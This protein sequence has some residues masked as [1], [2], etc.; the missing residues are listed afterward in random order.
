MSPLAPTLPANSRRSSRLYAVSRPA[1]IHRRVLWC[2]HRGLV[3]IQGAAGDG[4]RSGS[5]GRT[6]CRRDCF[7]RTLVAVVRCASGIC[8]NDGFYCRRGTFGRVPW[9]R[10]GAI[11]RDQRCQLVQLDQL[12]VNLDLLELV[13]KPRGEFVG[14]GG[15]TRLQHRRT[16]RSGRTTS[17]CHASTRDRAASGQEV[18][19]VCRRLAPMNAAN[20]TRLTSSTCRFCK[21]RHAA[22]TPSMS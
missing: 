3:G 8:P 17:R 19:S 20:N 4:E 10:V 11:E 14:C 18:V 12:G 7:D 1:S 5:S 13:T 16:A 9:N 21:Y 6:G 2:G 22:A 15:G